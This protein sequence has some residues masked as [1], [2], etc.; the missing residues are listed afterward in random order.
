MD[1][2]MKRIFSTEGWGWSLLLL[3]FVVDSFDFSSLFC[4]D[5]VFWSLSSL[6]FSLMLSRF[7]WFFFRNWKGSAW[8]EALPVMTLL[9]VCS[10]FR[11]PFRSVVYWERTVLSESWEASWI[12]SYLLMS[13]S[14]KADIFCCCSRIWDS[15]DSFSIC[16][17]WLM[18]SF[19]MFWS[20]FSHLCSY[21]SC[22]WGVFWEEEEDF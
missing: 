14:S 17:F 8:L 6:D 13:A 18:M 3:M 20:I 2:F 5:M 22:F 15:F 16:F 12:L 11:L 10:R 4:S 9:T 21:F 19:C 1:W 7:V